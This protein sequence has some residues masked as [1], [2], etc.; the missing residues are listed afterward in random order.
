MERFAKAEIQFVTKRYLEMKLNRGVKA[1]NFKASEETPDGQMVL[2]L[3]QLSD[4]VD[5]VL[6]AKVLMN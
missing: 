3:D 5:K 2:S 6:N 4:L 1:I